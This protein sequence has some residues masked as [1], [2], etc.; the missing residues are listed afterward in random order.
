MQTQFI[1]RREHAATN[2]NDRHG[3]CST[4]FESKPT[5]SPVSQSATVNERV[6][7]RRSNEWNRLTTRRCQH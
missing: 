2:G 3:R 7:Q 4:M 6:G 5:P 1:Q